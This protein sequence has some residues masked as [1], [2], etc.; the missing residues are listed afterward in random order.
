M[1]K[2]QLMLLAAFFMLIACPVLSSVG[3][4]IAAFVAF[5]AGL[6]VIAYALATGKVK[7]FG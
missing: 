6:L 4:P 2:G 5:L 7:L 3:Y 1:S